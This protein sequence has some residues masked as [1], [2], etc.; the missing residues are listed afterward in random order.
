MSRQ[1]MKYAQRLQR[2]KGSNMAKVKAV[3]TKQLRQHHAFWMTRCLDPLP[4]PK[5]IPEIVYVVAFAG[6]ALGMALFVTF[7]G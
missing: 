4:A 5:A 7:G 1:R 3:S 2:R 6:L